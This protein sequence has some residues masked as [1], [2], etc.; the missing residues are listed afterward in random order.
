MQ[1]KENDR[2]HFE[3]LV[4]QIAFYNNHGVLNTPKQFAFRE[5]GSVTKIVPMAAKYMFYCCEVQ[6]NGVSKNHYHQQKLCVMK[7][8]QRIYPRVHL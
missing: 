6:N 1:S 4:P 3:E 8:F 5:H 7:I 2:D